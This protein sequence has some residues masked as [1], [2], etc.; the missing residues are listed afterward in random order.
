[1]AGEAASPPKDSRTRTYAVVLVV[2]TL[3][4]VTL[5]VILPVVL[6]RGPTP[7]SPPLVGSNV[8]V[9][10]YESGSGWDGQFGDD[11][12]VASAP[13]GSLA[14]AWEGLYDVAPPATPD[15]TP[16]FAAA[17]FVSFSS[18]G[19]QHFSAPRFVASPGTVSAFLPSLAF[20]SNGTLFLAY[21]NAT[22]SDNQEIIV[23]SAAP[24]QNFTPG[25]VAERGQD[26]GRPW[27]LALP[28]GSLGLAFG[29]AGLVEWAL[30]TDGGQSF[31][32]PAILVEGYLTGAT[33]WGGGKVTLVGLSIGALTS[34]TVA[35]WSVTFDPTGSG[36]PQ[37]GAAV[38]ITMPYPV[39]VQLPN[40]SR[41]GPSVTAVGGLLYLWY[42]S[43]N[44]TE[45]DLMTSNTNGSSWGGP[46]TIW[47]PRN[48]TIETPVV[49]EAPNG[50]YLVL[51]WQS[52]QG[53]YWK[54]YSAVYNV[55]TG[56]LS[57][58]AAVSNADGFPSMVRNWHGTTMGLAFSDATR[59]VL[60]WGD[61]RGLTGTYGLTHIY[62]SGLTASF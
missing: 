20:D 22:D 52:T 8:Q 42:A 55:R 23:A 62:A 6:N 26:L 37:V 25:I 59:F 54:A 43:S 9:D 39:A 38:T 53:G 32:P 57:S 3:T 18:D 34:Q 47:S 60:V 40:L 51:G 1:M 15:G 46:Y 11:P 17:I 50:G 33:E 30:S 19:G 61:G 58:P 56:L 31:A 5:A 45:L 28:S 10:V 49:E 44:E 21:D 16:T 13:N 27:L 24:G 2:V 29:Y 48:T 4:V 12:V 14:V 35:V 41:P 7:P 36:A